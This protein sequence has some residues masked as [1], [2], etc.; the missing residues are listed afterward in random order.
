MVL[1]SFSGAIESCS[2]LL[3]YALAQCRPTYGPLYGY[4]ISLLMPRYLSNAGGIG[5]VKKV[6]VLNSA[7]VIQVA[8]HLL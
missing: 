1:P 7:V 5:V 4:L 3:L 8:L 2:E 6:W